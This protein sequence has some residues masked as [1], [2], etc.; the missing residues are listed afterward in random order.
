ME[1]IQ[2]SLLTL[3]VVLFTVMIV[4]TPNNALYRDVIYAMYS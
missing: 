4:Y 3:A 1:K 2:I